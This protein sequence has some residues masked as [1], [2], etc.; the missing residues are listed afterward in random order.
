MVERK[1]RL[2]I[3]APL[4]TDE[5]RSMIQRLREAHIPVSVN[6]NPEWDIIARAIN[7]LQDLHRH[8]TG[9]QF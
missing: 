2:Q 9:R 1:M 3:S 4:R 7:A 5:L 6:D 8:R